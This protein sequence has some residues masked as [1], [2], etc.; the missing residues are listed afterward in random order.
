M[1]WVGRKGLGRGLR[2]ENG[3][4]WLDKGGSPNWGWGVLGDIRGGFRYVLKRKPQMT[5]N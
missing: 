4:L 5:L 1:R 3:V 2:Q